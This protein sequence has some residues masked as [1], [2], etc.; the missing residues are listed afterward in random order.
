MAYIP[1]KLR[2]T[3]EQAAL[4]FN[5][6]ANAPLTPAREGKLVLNVRVQKLSDG[7]ECTITTYSQQPLE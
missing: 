7:S 6:K 5:N 3:K 1:K 4:S 2:E